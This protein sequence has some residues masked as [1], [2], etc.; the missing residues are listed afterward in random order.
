MVIKVAKL[1]S[2]LV[3]DEPRLARKLLEPLANVIQVRAAFYLA[4]ALPL[5][6]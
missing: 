5:I 1:M 3:Q 4:I 2:A 6:T